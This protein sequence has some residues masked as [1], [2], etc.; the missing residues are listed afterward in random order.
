MMS[1]M[2]TLISHAS[3]RAVRDVAFPMDEPLDPQ[4]RA[5]AAAL[6][7]EIRR[8]DAAWTSPAL[9]ARQT[10]DALTLSATIEPALRD[11]DYGN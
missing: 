9:R 3:T 6:A 10:A 11:I 8:V 4:G 5:Q 7:G 2:L 1:V